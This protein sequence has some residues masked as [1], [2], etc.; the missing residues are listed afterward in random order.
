MRG[1]RLVCALKI[2]IMTDGGE[3]CLSLIQTIDIA[4]ELLILRL[5]RVLWG[6]LICDHDAIC[7]IQRYILNWLHRDK[8]KWH[9]L[10]ILS[11]QKPRYTLLYMRRRIEQFWFAITLCPINISSCKYLRIAI[12]RHNQTISTENRSTQPIN[13]LYNKVAL[14]ALYPKKISISEQYIAQLSIW[15]LESKDITNVS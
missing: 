3:Q 13:M 11:N 5:Y 8:N 4:W 14:S 1:T 2:Q 7:L 12:K 15:S 10:E 6:L 9:I